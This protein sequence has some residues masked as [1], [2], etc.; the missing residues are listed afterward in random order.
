MFNQN[1]TFLKAFKYF[2]YHV[3]MNNTF[4]TYLPSLSKPLSTSWSRIVKFAGL[5]KIELFADWSNLFGVNRGGVFH[6]LLNSIAWSF[7]IGPAN[8][9][10]STNES[11]GS[12]FNCCFKRKHY[13]K[14]NTYIVK[15]KFFLTGGV[16]GE[17]GSPI[18]GCK[19]ISSERN[20]GIKYWSS[21]NNLISFAN[22]LSSIS[23]LVQII[24]EV[25]NIKN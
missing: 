11:I 16:E 12:F 8:A 23:F 7:V 2:S 1:Q 18:R 14:I 5:F 4:F 6:F 13:G 15:N 3:N 25:T 9:F 21:N 22:F 17:N 19:V 10:T 24:C 20:T